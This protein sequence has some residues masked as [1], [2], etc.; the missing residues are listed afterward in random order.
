[1]VGNNDSKTHPGPNPINVFSA[2]IEAT[3]KFDRS[4]QL[5]KVTWPL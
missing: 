4:V 3:L 2:S 1:L 5:K